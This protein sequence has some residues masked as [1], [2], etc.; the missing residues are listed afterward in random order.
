MAMTSSLSHAHFYYSHGHMVMSSS[1][2]Y[3]H[4]YY[5]HGHMAMSSSLSHAH[6]YYSHGHMAMSSSLSYAHSYQYDHVIYVQ[7][8]VHNTKMETYTI[9]LFKFIFFSSQEL[10]A[11]RVSQ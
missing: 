6:F 5:S 4:F 10:A 8:I 9:S 3:A 11:C 7:Y 1:L 2:S